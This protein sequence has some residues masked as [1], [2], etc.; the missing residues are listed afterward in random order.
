MAEAAIF[1]TTGTEE[2]EA[3]MVVDLVRRAGIDID[4]VSIDES[5]EMTGS[6]NIAVKLDKTISE[7]DWENTQ[8]LILPG[9]LPGTNNLMACDKLTDKLKEFNEQGKLLAAICAAPSILGMNGILEGRR[10][11]CYPGHEDK[12]LGAELV[13][14]PVVVCDN[15]I[16]S[17]GLGTA[18]DFAAAIIGV[19]RSQDKADEILK[20]IIYQTEVE[21]A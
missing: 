1:M 3:L 14:E 7:V 15:V 16:T 18:I 6:H 9:G 21:G 10:A 20:K 12:L 17:R 2:V 13:K 19:L 5:R 8:M 11:T 4:M